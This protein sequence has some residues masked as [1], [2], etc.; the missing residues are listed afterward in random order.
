MLE[1]ITRIAGFI[2]K[3]NHTATRWILKAG[4]PATKTPE[5][6]WLSHK[7]LILQWMFAGHQAEL[8]AR[9]PYT[10]EDDEITYLS[11]K[12]CIQPYQLRIMIDGAQKEDGAKKELVDGNQ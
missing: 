6:R 4:L 1:G 5:G 11:K 10:F 3:S 9:V 12:L 8:A 7:G 2:G